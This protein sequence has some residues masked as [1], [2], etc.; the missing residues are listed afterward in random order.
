MWGLSVKGPPGLDDGHAAIRLAEV[1]VHGDPV[2]AE[3]HSPGRFIHRHLDALANRT[4]RPRQP[5]PQ[6]DQLPIPGEHLPAAGLLDLVPAEFRSLD[7]RGVL[8]VGDALR[9]PTEGG[10]LAPPALGYRS[11]QVGVGVVG[12]VLEGRARGPFL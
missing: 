10:E 12:E 3:R 7:C 11:T 4:T 6:S 5:S 1:H 8:R 2:A 9:A